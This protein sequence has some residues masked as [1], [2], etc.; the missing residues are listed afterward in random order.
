MLVKACVSH[1]RICA[2]APARRQH[3][4]KTSVTTAK[5]QLPGR[6][7]GIETCFTRELPQERLGLIA[8]QVGRV[9]AQ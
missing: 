9:N 6:S 4:A 8:V 7:A 2:V 5:V 1:N 3:D